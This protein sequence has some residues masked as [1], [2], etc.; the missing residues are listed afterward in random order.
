[1]AIA[2]L[3]ENAAADAINRTT[4]M[5]LHSSYDDTQAAA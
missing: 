3:A 5:R 2:K 1:L 4:I